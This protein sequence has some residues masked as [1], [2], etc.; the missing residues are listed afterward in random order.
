ME[1][2]SRINNRTVHFM[3]NDDE[4]LELESRYKSSNYKTK[5]EFFRDLI[6]K[7]KIVV[8]DPSGEFRNELR[9]L[10]SLIS[11]NAANINQIAKKVNSTEKIEIKDIDLIK[12]TL[13]EEVLY[14]VDFREKLNDNLIN[15]VLK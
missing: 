6:M 7:E 5:R 10:T 4:Y 15:K 11:R 3:V 9:H 12:K 8:I 1:K 14:L 2:A 13:K